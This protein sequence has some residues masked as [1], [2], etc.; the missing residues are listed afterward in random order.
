[1]LPLLAALCLCSTGYCPLWLD[2]YCSSGLSRLGAIGPVDLRAV[3]E[4][5][6]LLYG[7]L[8]LTGGGGLG[9]SGAAGGGAEDGSS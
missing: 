8:K 6:P 2:R 3:W 4:E 1:M 9:A 7:C 5:P